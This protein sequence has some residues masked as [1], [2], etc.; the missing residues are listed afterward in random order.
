M[1]VKLQLPAA[2]VVTSH[3]VGAFISG[4]N[5][6]RPCP[7]QAA[8]TPL[9]PDILGRQVKSDKTTGSAGR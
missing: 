4:R 3:H 9:L 7:R 1:R 6:G 5:S 8:T 2:P